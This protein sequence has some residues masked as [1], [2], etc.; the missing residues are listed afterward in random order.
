MCDFASDSGS[1]SWDTLCHG[2]SRIFEDYIGERG[3]VH[4]SILLQVAKR[5]DAT[6]SA[7]NAAKS[8]NLVKSGKIATGRVEPGNDRMI[9]LRRDH[10]SAL[11]AGRPGFYSDQYGVVHEGATAAGAYAVTTRGTPSLAIANEM[12]AFEVYTG[13][14]GAPSQDEVSQARDRATIAAAS[15][16]ATAA[17]CNFVPRDPNV[18]HEDL[19]LITA[20]DGQPVRIWRPGTTGSYGNKEQM[21]VTFDADDAQH[22]MSSGITGEYKQGFPCVASSGG[23]CSGPCYSNSPSTLRVLPTGYSARL[24]S[25]NGW[26]AAGKHIEVPAGF[27]SL[28]CAWGADLKT[29]S[30]LVYQTAQSEVADQGGEL[31]H[32]PTGKDWE[33]A[34]S[35]VEPWDSE[36]MPFLQIRLHDATDASKDLLFG[37]VTKGHG[38]MELW[39]TKYYVSVDDACS[40]TLPPYPYTRPED[41]ASRTDRSFVSDGCFRW[42][43]EDGYTCK[44]TDAVCNRRTFVGNTDH[45]TEVPRLFSD[46]PSYRGVSNVQRVRIHP[47]AYDSTETYLSGSAATGFT[48]KTFKWPAMRWGLIMDTAVEVL[49]PTMDKRKHVQL[50]TT[51][52]DGVTYDE[53]IVEDQHCRGRSGYLTSHGSTVGF[54][55]SPHPP[56]VENG[57]TFVDGC[58]GNSMIGNDLTSNNLYCGNSNWASGTE[59]VFVETGATAGTRHPDA[60]YVEMDLSSVVTYRGLVI[61]FPG[62]MEPNVDK[63]FSHA[64]SVR[65]ELRETETGDYVDVGCSIKRG[66]VCS[67]PDA[68]VANCAALS[69]GTAPCTNAESALYTHLD[70]EMHITIIKVP[71][72]FRVA[73]RFVRVYPVSVDWSLIDFVPA[74]YMQL[75]VQISRRPYVQVHEEHW[76]GDDKKRQPDEERLPHTVN[77]ICADLTGDGVED[78]IV[79]RTQSEYVSCAARCHNL[80]RV[81]FNDHVADTDTICRCGPT[82]EAMRAPAHPPSAPPS[83]PSPPSPPPPPLPSPP[84][85]PPPPPHHLRHRAGMCVLFGD[86]DVANLYLPQ[87]PPPMPP[88]SPPPPFNVPPPSAPPSPNP[89]SPPALPPSPP[90]LPP[91]PPPLS[92]PPLPPAPPPRP[93]RPP[94]PFL[95]DRSKSP[96]PSA[97]PL[98]DTTQSRLIHRPLDAATADIL[99]KNAEATGWI[100]T[101][102]DVLPSPRGYQDTTLLEGAWLQAGD[103]SERQ[104]VTIGQLGVNETE[105][106][107]CIYR[108]RESTQELFYRNEVC[109]KAGASET[110]EPL[111]PTKFAPRCIVVLINAES[112]RDLFEFMLSVGRRA[113]DPVRFNLTYATTLSETPDYEVASINVAFSMMLQLQY[114]ADLVGQVGANALAAAEEAVRQKDAQT[115]LF[116][117]TYKGLSPTSAAAHDMAAF[118]ARLELLKK[119]QKELRAELDA[120]REEALATECVISLDETCG[121]TPSAAPDPWVAA[122]GRN[123]VGKS[124]K[125]AMPGYYCA[126]WGSPN[127]VDAANSQEAHELMTDSPPTCLSED[128]D[129]DGRRETLDCSVLAESTIRSGVYELEELARLD[130]RF[131]CQNPIFRELFIENPNV[132]EGKCRK[133]LL[134]RKENCEDEVCPP[135]MAQ[136]T[137]PTIKTIA[138]V[139]KCTLQSDQVGF[140]WGLE[141]SD[142]GQ[143]AKSLHDADRGT[144]YIAVCMPRPAHIT[145]HALICSFARA[146]SPEVGK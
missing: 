25:T 115:T 124:T 26:M 40:S 80:G 4:K 88:T 63:S 12:G 65:I 41:V 23:L 99:A 72:I 30:T 122:D 132:L 103:C 144:N 17:Y 129:V 35:T 105:R 71:A 108:L 82:Y 92:P 128:T 101:G 89:P 100:V 31:H 104:H 64:Y 54:I 70:I 57:E 52:T 98:L 141:V 110:N 112:H 32:Y 53:A 44:L 68:Q 79:H 42:I 33:V 85:S 50:G 93:P 15:H 106:S 13:N 109:H 77:V 28:P 74:A 56:L 133:E 86:V 145:H 69:G 143:L 111:V 20:G 29:R 73:T 123:C 83:P 45:D 67:A 14:G 8:L 94:P 62:D 119:E 16:S 76:R 34:D 75:A 117:R 37:V 24:G 47:I 27:G 21:H 139:I 131:Y 43:D 118:A 84:P 121:R 9:V 120:L 1:A 60:T 136:C 96:P 127:N 113:S 58:S 39:V 90:P 137:T 102:A 97:P 48:T 116:E 7:R 5:P 36:E 38:Q 107:Q 81:G 46:D 22:S 130:R 6:G 134:A 18:E 142:Q 95:F 87:T 114:A 2:R 78:I 3:H 49:N 91:F 55:F 140:A 59:H 11:I 66:V 126:R 138:G 51:C 19:D 125:E 10:V 146:D 135:C 61:G